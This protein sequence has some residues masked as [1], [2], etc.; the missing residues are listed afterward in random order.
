MRLA[1]YL[2]Y[3]SI[4]A[5]IG[6][7]ALFACS[8]TSAGNPVGGG[9]APGGGSGGSG[10]GVGATSGAAGSGSGI[11]FDA[12][13]D[14]GPTDASACG[15]L[16]AEAQ[17]EVKP[18]DIIFVID[19]S[20]SMNTEAQGVQDNISTNFAQIISASGVDYRVIMISDSGPT[21]SGSVC[22][23]PPLGGSVCPTADGVPPINNPPLFYHYDKG[24]VESWDGWCKAMAWYDQPSEHDATLQ[25]W[26]TWLRP[27]AYKAFVSIT[28]DRVDCNAGGTNPGSSCTTPG[29]KCYDDQ[30]STTGAL[31]TAQQF[32]ADLMA[33]DPAQFGSVA[34]RKYIWYS[35]V[36][37]AA[38]PADPTGAYQPTEAMTSSKCTSAVNTSYGN[39]ALSQIT[40]GLRFPVCEGFNFSTVFQEIAKGVIAG[41]KIACEFALPTPPEGKEF[42]LNSVTV[43]FTAGGTTTPQTL[44]QAP[45]LAACSAGKFY[46]DQDRVYLCPDACGLVQQD[47]D[48]KL[49]VLVDCVKDI[50]R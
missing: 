22:I 11:S 35:I 7:G 10:A 37:V 9:A 27:E 20:C 29:P 40:G 42:D 33:L 6:S 24:N 12:G 19:N 30:S 48:G 14:S 32:D 39:Q 3:A 46:I 21:S 41:A 45:S 15:K 23:G 31:A 8:S 43:N 44:T 13:G 47:P 17:I 50:P 34:E 4:G 36:G 5:L 1:A 25:G 28:D 38:N 2:G 18:V 16:Q 26:K 49:D